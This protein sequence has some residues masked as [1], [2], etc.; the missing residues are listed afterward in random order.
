ML[1]NVFLKT[2]R[3]LRMGLLAWGIGIAVLVGSMAAVW[4]SIRTMPDIEEFLASYPEAMREIFNVE[5]ITTGAGF[6][7]AELYSILL[8][9]LFIIFAIGRGARM[10]A[11]EEEAGTLEVLLVTPASRSRVLLDKAAALAV[12]LVAL[13]VVLLVTTWVA[14]AVVGMGIGL[15]DAAN[16][17][18]AM[19]LLGLAHGWLGLAVGAASGRRPLAVGV[20]ATVAV[21]GYVLYVLSLLVDALEPW[22]PWSPFEQALRGGPLGG[23]VQ[24]SYLW[25]A[26]AAVVFVAAALPL[27]DR[28]DV[29]AH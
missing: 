17:S 24:A 21:A 8:P 19:V 16:G 22:G 20:A 18:L 3:D 29:L 4:P 12:A 14:S 2:L 7:N 9:A 27:F 6:L 13:G 25:L 1:Q 23:G 10:V 26:L 28:R 5:A 15:A 11:G